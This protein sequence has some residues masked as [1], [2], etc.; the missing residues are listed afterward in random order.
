MPA[1]DLCAVNVQSVK[2]AMIWIFLVIHA[3][4]NPNLNSSFQQRALPKV[5]GRSLK[6]C[7]VTS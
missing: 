7:T 3:N 5:S 4:K 6:P 2:L 1:F